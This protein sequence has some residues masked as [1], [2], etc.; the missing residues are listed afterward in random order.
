MLEV[1]VYCPLLRISI[2]KDGNCTS[3]RKMAKVGQRILTI[4]NATLDAELA[5]F[6]SGYYRFKG[7]PTYND[8][9]LRINLGAD[10]RDRSALSEIRSALSTAYPRFQDATITE[11]C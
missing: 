2:H 8:M 10:E 11:H 1:H 3:I 5:R 4:N 6:R 7:E 9:W